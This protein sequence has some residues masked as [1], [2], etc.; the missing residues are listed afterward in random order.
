MKSHFRSSGVAL[1]IVLA[2]LLLIA[3]VL[4]MFLTAVSMERRA[5]TGSQALVSNRQL[6]DM[7]VSLVQAQIR[8]ATTRGATVAWASQP[9]MIRTFSSGG[10]VD[11]AY[12]LYSSTDFSVSN[13]L[14]NNLAAEFTNAVA[15][16]TNSACYADM[17]APVT[18]VAGN[19]TNIIF[20]IADPRALG[21]VD[22]FSFTTDFGATNTDASP[23]LPMPVQW[24]YV[25]QDGTLVTPA[26][27]SSKTLNLTNA[28][29]SNPVVG[30]IAYW[31]DD[32]SAKININTASEGTFW[33]TPRA[34]SF[35]NGSNGITADAYLA[36]NQPAKGEFQSY[37]GH[38]ATTSLSPV[39]FGTNTSNYMPIG[40]TADTFRSLICNLMPK[41]ADGGS[42]GGTTPTVPGAAGSSSTAVSG[43][44]ASL[45]A[46]VDEMFFSPKGRVAQT[47]AGQTGLNQT[48]LEQ[49]RFFLT[50]NSRAPE[51]NLF[52]LPRVSLWPVSSNSGTN[53]QTPF[54]KLNLFCS[55]VG[56]G[57]SA[58][59]FAFTRNSPTSLDDGFAGSRNEALFNYL[60]ALMNNPIPGASGTFASKYPNDYQQILVEIYDYIRLANLQDN[61][62]NSTSFVPFT[63]AFVKT[64]GLN[65]NTPG[66]GQVLP[67]RHPSLTNP[68]GQA[69]QGFGRFCVVSEAALHFFAEGLPPLPSGTN[70]PKQSQT[71]RAAFYLELTTL[72]QGYCSYSPN[73]RITVNH[74]DQLSVVT[75]GNTTASMGFPSSAKNYCQVNAAAASTF[76]SS[77]GGSMGVIPEM[78]YPTTGNHP[79]KTVNTNSTQTPNSDDP[80]VYP[81]VSGT[82]ELP[83]TSTTTTN[84]NV[85]AVEKAAA[86]AKPIDV[87]ATSLADYTTNSWASYQTISGSNIIT[88]TTTSQPFQFVGNVD[89]VEVI[90][91]APT[92]SSSS[93]NY[94]EVQRYKF[95]FPNATLP[96]PVGLETTLQKVNGANVVV[97]LT[98]FQARVNLITSGNIGPSILIPKGA[99][100]G[101]NSVTGVSVSSLE[102]VRSLE[103]VSS[104]LRLLAVMTNVPAGYFK[105]CLNYDTLN[106]LSHSLTAGTA[107]ATRPFYGAKYGD[108]IPGNLP[109]P[110]YDTPNIS[111]RGTGETN[112]YGRPGDFDTGVSCYISGPWINKPDEGDQGNLTKGLSP[113]FS[114]SS[115]DQLNEPLTSTL[116]SAN[117]QLPSPGVLGSLPTG[118]QS[119]NPWQTLLFCPNPAAVQA[120]SDVLSA[121]VHRG[122]A[123]PRDHLLMDLFWIPM[124]EPY[125]ISDS[126]STAG[127]VN[128]NTQIIP[129]TNITRE[130][131]LEGVLK[132]VKITALPG[133]G[134]PAAPVWSHMKS[135]STMPGVDNNFRYDLDM[136]ATLAEIRKRFVN[137]GAYMSA[138]EICE[139]LLIPKSTS[140]GSASANNPIS[141]VGLTGATVIPSFWQKNKWTGDNLREQPYTVIYPRITTK[142]NVYTVHYM[143]QT[144]KKVPGS[145][146]SGWDEN[147]DKVVG[148]LRGNATIERFIDPN[149]PAFNLSKNNFTQAVAASPNLSNVPTL[150]KFYKFRVIATHDFRP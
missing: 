39:L 3:A 19:Q 116:F 31:T 95:N 77:T 96:T 38:P 52:N 6:S 106:W 85:S 34:G 119:G 45:Y 138:S 104:D 27:T 44:D 144:L 58:Q 113:Y 25:L 57:T 36:L 105:T 132:S 2:S 30:R 136:D 32:D 99:P 68:T 123:S 66:A 142:S 26:S 75:A 94:V 124:V 4:V 145:T 111:T 97:G 110:L 61:S 126:F 127:K 23:K 18:Q 47:T 78:L 20:P 148:E 8:Q 118:S 42:K 100:S 150:D 70:S 139:V 21:K 29:P 121:S 120:T 56:S 49:T 128:L 40:T 7:A 74:L 114:I 101:T 83:I 87:N 55:T 22:G 107:S 73:L 103:P 86:T 15:N 48:A 54:D 140:G 50:A 146:A 60:L 33:D 51:V 37:P 43:S 92:S 129:F 134:I 89:P 82:F 93:P 102:V 28:S 72:G 115:S 108:L 46:S 90:V 81:F 12:K 98:N 24:I 67:F 64:A 63:P 13:N 14:S 147:K 122:F 16:W 69:L 35:G 5:A 10:S 135:D 137:F 130:T 109:N 11:T 141:A 79:Q 125:A 91:E 133:G 117:R 88:T 59:V 71:V 65:G 131:G 80:T 112:Q 84:T 1:V 9:G 149:D 17:N 143:V 41:Y 76:H 53:Y 62:Q